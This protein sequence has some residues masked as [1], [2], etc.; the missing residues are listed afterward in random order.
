MYAQ[1]VLQFQ[2][3]P[4]ETLHTLLGWSED[5]HIVFFFRILKLIFITFYCIFNLDFFVFFF[6]FFVTCLIHCSGLAWCMA[7]SFFFLFFFFLF[8]FFVCLFVCF[9]CFFFVVC[10]FCLF[11]F[12]I[13]VLLLTFKHRKRLQSFSGLV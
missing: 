4:F 9:C 8:F 10:L 3:N 2:A 5:I 7:C 1:L 13:V 11:F 12:L 6:F